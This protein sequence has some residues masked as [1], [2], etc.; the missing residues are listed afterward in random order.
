MVGTRITILILSLFL[1][2][3]C[4]KNSQSELDFQ[5]PENSYNI[6]IE[7]GINTLVKQQYIQIS[8]PSLKAEEAPLPVTE[9]Q[10]SVNDGYKE[11]SFKMTSTPGLYSAYM[12]GNANY[13][14]AYKLTVKYKNVTYS[15][16][17]TLKQVVDITDDYLPFTAK[18][19][20]D[21]AVKITIPKHSFGYMNSGKWLIAYTGVPEWNPGKIGGP[22]YYNYTHTLGTPNAL[23]PLIKDDREVILGPDDL[24]SIYKFSL[25]ET[26][27]RYLY[28]I[29]LETDWKGIFSS[30]PGKITGNISGNAQGFF[31]VTDIDFRKYRV[32]EFITQ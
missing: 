29:F 13:N 7:G 14:K 6:V 8:L 30:V 24:I 17:D 22:Q 21:G 23:Y 9:A 19:Q 2:A 18:K 25:S 12:S 11:I 32:K 28:S 4:D 31:Y 16:T 1:L 10:V 3:G 27:S 26:Y 5:T 20:V 15:A